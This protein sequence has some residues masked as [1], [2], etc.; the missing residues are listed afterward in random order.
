M[1]TKL[2]FVLSYTESWPVP[3]YITSVLP[4]PLYIHTYLYLSNFGR[5]FL[6]L[7]IILH[8]GRGLLILGIE[9][10]CDDTGAAIVDGSGQVLGD[11]LKSQSQLHTEWVLFSGGSSTVEDFSL[12]WGCSLH[13]G[14]RNH[15]LQEVHVLSETNS[16]RELLSEKLFDC[17]STILLPLGKLQDQLSGPFYMYLP[18]NPHWHHWCPK[19]GYESDS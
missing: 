13:M 15:S 10:S 19:L 4:H 16:P 17:N 1:C 2:S 11:V 7:F 18:L 5:Y 8:T 12:V 6:L 3:T 14:L 9:T